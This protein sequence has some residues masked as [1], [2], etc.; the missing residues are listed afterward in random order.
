MQSMESS[1]SD[2][3]RKQYEGEKLREIAVIQKKCQKDI[4]T[5]RT[6][7]HSLTHS[8][9]HLLIHLLA[10][11]LTYSLTHSQMK[12]KIRCKKLKK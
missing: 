2:A 10:H 7:T 8:L 5:I 12:E 3:V 1:I 9:T 11:L 4:E 6:G